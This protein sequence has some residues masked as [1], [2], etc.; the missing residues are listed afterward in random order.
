MTSRKRQVKD[1]TEISKG[2]SKAT[3]DKSK[4]T[5]QDTKNISKGKSKGTNDKSKET[6]QRIQTT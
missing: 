6:S 3:N 4:E 2:K 5:S 1:A